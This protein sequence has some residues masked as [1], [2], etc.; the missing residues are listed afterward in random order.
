MRYA[1]NY[2]YSI[3]VLFKKNQDK[4]TLLINDSNP[5][6]INKIIKIPIPN[7]LNK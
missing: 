6:S 4:A 2:Y 7:T 5:N 3:I 1:D